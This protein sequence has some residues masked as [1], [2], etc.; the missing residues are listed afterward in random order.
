MTRLVLVGPNILPGFFYC[1]NN[2]GVGP[3]L[4]SLKVEDVNEA[5]YSS[6]YAKKDLLD[7]LNNCSNLQVLELPAFL[8]CSERNLRLL[9]DG[10]RR[11]D[12]NSGGDWT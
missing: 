3:A 1:A 6:P 9:D 12:R 5:E 11:A 8:A 2:Y 10:R 7:W 4:T